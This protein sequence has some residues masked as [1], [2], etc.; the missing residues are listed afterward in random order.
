[1]I[2][3]EQ[4]DRAYRV[5]YRL[6]FPVVWCWWRLFQRHQGVVV[7]VWLNDTILAVRHS[8]KP[9]LRLLARISQCAPTARFTSGGRIH[10]GSCR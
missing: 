9:G 8:Y 3:Q 4:V 6:V 7:A 10:P 1:M 5:A 2:I